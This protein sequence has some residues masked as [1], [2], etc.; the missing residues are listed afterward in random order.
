MA[1][2]TE[3]IAACCKQ[4]RLSSNLADRAM[5]QKG[6]TNQEY[7]CKLLENEIE[8]RRKTRIIKLQNSAGF[9]KRYAPEQFR[10]DEV[11]FPDG[12]SFESLMGL[13]FHKQGRNIIMYGGT[14][15]GKTMLSILVGIQACK[16]G[17]PVRFYR[18]AGLINL[19]TESHQNGTLTALKRKL[20]TAQIIILDEFGY[21]P[22]DRTG[23]QLLFD[24]LSEIHEQKEVILNTNLEFS[25]W[26]NVLYDKRMT[27]ALIGRL[28]HHVE[29]ILFPGGNNRLRE[30]SINVGMSASNDQEVANG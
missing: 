12:V 9:P 26:V 16:E 3:R 29:L 30:S 7:L 8:Y 21:V 17:I 28:T 19:F 4:L 1:D 23:S 14:G 11:D 2:Y 20:N 27:T 5:S 22:Y 10:T 18:T 25:Q 24:Y 6:K 15:T 13:D